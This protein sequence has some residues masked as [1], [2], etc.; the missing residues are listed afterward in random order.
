MRKL[1]L[2]GNRDQAV[3]FMKDILAAAWKRLGEDSFR[4]FN[5][6]NIINMVYP[7]PILSD[8]QKGTLQKDLHPPV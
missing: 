1:D 6:H 3:F 7:P 5:F 4:K 2:N 8:L